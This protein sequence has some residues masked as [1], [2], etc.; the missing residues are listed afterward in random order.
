MLIQQK[1][2]KLVRFRRDAALQNCRVLD[3]EKGRGK[4]RDE[5]EVTEGFPSALENV[6]YSK[7]T[8]QK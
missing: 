3:R 4:E 7:M 1:A 5:R 2:I 8:S 6:T